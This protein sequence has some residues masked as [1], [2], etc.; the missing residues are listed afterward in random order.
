M[1]ASTRAATRQLTVRVAPLL[2]VALAALGL[3]GADLAALSTQT[4]F[5]QVSIESPADGASAALPLHVLAHIGR[6]GEQ[7]HVLLQW[8]NAIQLDRAFTLL[9]DPDGQGLLI[10]NLDW[11]AG[12]QPALPSSDAAVLELRTE[13]GAVLASREVTILGPGNTGLRAITLYFVANADRVVPVQRRIPATPRIAAATLNELLWGPAPGDPPQLT[14]ALPRADDVL[15]YPGR[16]GN[17]GSR[18]QLLGVTIADGLAKANFSRELGAYGGGSLR[19]GLI[20]QQITDTL[21]QFDSVRKV[22]IAVEG[23]T[24]GVLE[25]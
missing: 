24:G 5:A 14:T 21:M 19:V 4:A 8:R 9:A 25:P 23:Q 20:D 15:A 6:P 18:V 13:S 17:W 7:I 10:A 2:F 12:T 1:A 22:A 3:G 16:K 11:D